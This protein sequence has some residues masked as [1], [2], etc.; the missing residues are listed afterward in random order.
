MKTVIV[1][2][3]LSPAREPIENVFQHEFE[4]PRNMRLSAPLL[5]AYMYEVEGVDV[6]KIVDLF[7]LTKFEAQ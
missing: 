3:T 6:Y 2:Y 1:R 7:V 4:I 5:K